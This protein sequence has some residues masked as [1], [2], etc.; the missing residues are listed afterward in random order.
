M[1]DQLDLARWLTSKK[2]EEYGIDESTFTEEIANTL[3]TF[4]PG[5]NQDYVELGYHAGFWTAFYL[6]HK[7]ASNDNEG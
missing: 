3:M 5:E 2:I 1:S 6:L 7:V 4:K